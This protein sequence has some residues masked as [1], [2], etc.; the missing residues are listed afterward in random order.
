MITAISFKSSGQEL[1]GNGHDPF[2]D[3]VRANYNVSTCQYDA[4]YRIKSLFDTDTTISEARVIFS[5]EGSK[6]T[7]LH[8]ETPELQEELIFFHDTVWY[9]LPGKNEFMMLGTEIQAMAGNHMQ[10]FFPSSLLTADTLLLHADPFWK[11]QKIN[12]P[13]QTIDFAIANLPEE[14]ERLHYEVEFDT[15]KNLLRKVTEIALF[16]SGVGV[17]FQEKSLYN[18]HFPDPSLIHPPP[19]FFEMPR[20]IPDR[21]KPDPETSVQTAHPELEIY[22]DGL[23]LT[24]VMGEPYDLPEEGL[25]FIDLW[26]VGCYPCM[27]SSPVV[28]RLYLEFKDRV[29]FVGVN[30]VDKDPE[31]IERYRSS[32]ALSFPVLLNASEKITGRAGISGYPAFLLADAATRKLLWSYS[33]YQEDLESI[34]RQAISGQLE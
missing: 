21:F 25:L 23:E 4:R 29:Y 20:I 2:L 26:Y 24:T 14:M 5:K 19:D 16:K 33:G 3:F 27:K 9:R 15:M 28:E 1:P 12:G 31:K 13:M 6:V 32:M 17:Q 30:E 8:I 18:H 34:I 7:F 22:L 11:V 10:N